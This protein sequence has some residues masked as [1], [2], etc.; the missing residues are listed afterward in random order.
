MAAQNDPP[1][2]LEETIAVEVATPLENGPAT[3]P[4]EEDKAIEHE[5][6]H[7]KL[8]WEKVQQIIHAIEGNTDSVLTEYDIK[9]AVDAGE[10][11][12]GDC[13]K[14][15]ARATVEGADDLDYHW[16]VKVPPEDPGRWPLTRAMKAEEKEIEF[17]R[18]TVPAL[19]KFAEENN[20]DMELV[21][22]QCVYTEFHDDMSKGSIIVLEDMKHSGF[23]DPVDKK[24]GLSLDYVKMGLRGYAELHALSFAYFNSH[25][26]GIDKALE[27]N[28]L[29]TTCVIILEPSDTLKKIYENFDAQDKE[30]KEDLLEAVQDEG[31]D[32]VGIY[33]KFSEENVI[34]EY[35]GKM[36]SSKASSFNTLC[37]GDAW[38]NNMLFR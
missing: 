31:E 1:P 22:P 9:P 18:E 4:D 20:Y 24:Q 5:D 34:K 27:E 6:K 3:F 7:Y 36:Y 8:T 17:Y 14:V 32:F 35:L 37:H 26:E 10:N 25:P 12:V 15:Y 13:V 33:R 21:F 38:F 2:V 29:V 30:M 16:V 23:S 19:K 11:F 28:Q